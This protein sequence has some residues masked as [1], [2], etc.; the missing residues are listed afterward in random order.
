M[1]GDGQNWLEY[2]QICNGGEIEIS[3]YVEYG[4]LGT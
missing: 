3:E 2:V 1:N 4:N